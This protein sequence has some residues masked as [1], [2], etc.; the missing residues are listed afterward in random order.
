MTWYMHRGAKSW[1]KTQKQSNLQ[2][3][4]NYSNPNL[5]AVFSSVQ[6]SKSAGRVI[7]VDIYTT[8]VKILEKASLIA[9]LWNGCW[10]GWKNYSQ[11]E[12]LS[13][14]PD[15]EIL[16]GLVCTSA[17]FRFLS[18]WT[19]RSLG[20]LAHFS[21]ICQGNL[22]VR[23]PPPNSMLFIVMKLSLLVSNIVGGEGGSLFQ[24]CH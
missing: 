17:G 2:P 22:S 4:L 8:V 7:I 10:T 9:M 15:V 14:A 19:T 16:Q 24:W 20:T 1:M 18:P 11:Q 6:S 13:C 5:T 12:L 21:S 23:P 3:N